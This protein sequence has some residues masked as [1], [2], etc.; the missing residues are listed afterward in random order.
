M[1]LYTIDGTPCYNELNLRPGYIHEMIT[2]DNRYIRPQRAIYFILL[3]LIL[4]VF[5]TSACGA[6]DDETPATVPEPVLL[7]EPEPTPQNDIDT[8]SRSFLWK[9]SSEE[10]FVYLLGSIHVAKP[11]IYPLDSVIEDAFLLADN[12]VVEVDINEV[13][14]QETLR[15]VMEYGT[16]PEGDGFK[17][18]VSEELYTKLNE[19]FWQFG[20]SIK[21][22][23]MYKPWFIYLT[24]DQ[25][26]WLNL[27]YQPE[28]GIDY[29]FL[30]K[31]I[32]TEKD[33]IEL[34]TAED[35]IEL[36][37]LFSD[38]LAI[39]ILDEYVD[40]MPTQEDIQLLFDAWEDGDAAEMEL[41]IFE[42]LVEEPALAPFYEMMFDERNFDI[43]VRIDEFLAEDEVYFIVV[44]AGHLVG[45]NGL[46]NLL[47]DRG[48]EIEQLYDSD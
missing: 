5:L 37:S 22:L 23:D 41:L 21:L 39:M 36:L 25:L 13:D 3:F 14:A 30:D 32:T 38:E 26:T 29:Y 6:P 24:L 35:Q 16:Y 33:I 7:T 12:L 48:Y 4:F 2:N 28:Y 44:G 17:D 42:A 11:T 40:N 8:G 1:K 46:I 18:N 15:L 10:N 45:E 19:Q 34:E 31:A 43:V 20:I 47:D 9:I 27:G